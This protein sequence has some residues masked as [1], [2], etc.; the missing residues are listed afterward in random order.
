MLLYKTSLVI[1]LLHVQLFGLAQNRIKQYVQ[2]QAVEVKHIDITDS[3]FT[4]L[5]PLGVAIGNARIVALGEQMHGDGTTFE[6]K[7]RIVKYL[8]EKKGFNVLVFENDFFGLTDGFERVLKNRD[9]LNNFIFHHVIGLWSHCQRARSFF[10]NYIYQTQSTASPLILAGMDCQ[11][12]TTY[13]FQNAEAK[14][15]RILS[16]LALSVEDSNRVKIATDHLPAIYFNGQKADSAACKKGLEAVSTLLASKALPQLNNEE[17]N[18][19]ENIYAAYRNILP[20]LAGTIASSP[21]HLYRDRQMFNNLMWLMK[22]KFPNEKFIIWAH[23]AHIAKAV[24]DFADN[25]HQVIMTGELLGNKNINPYSYY[26]L[27][28]TSYNA[29]SIWT[30]NPSQPIYAEKPSK[31]SFENWINKNWNFA[32]VDWNKLN[33]NTAGN[34]PFSMKG[35]LEFTQHRNSVNYWNKLYDGVF[36]IRRVEGCKKI[37]YEDINVDSSSA[38]TEYSSDNR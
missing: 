38:A 34:E 26:S 14:L 24:K 4:D 11:L 19:V 6:A 32:F 3:Q 15:Y 12:Q 13:S 5:E 8:H 22:Y 27:G 18:F 28:F 35:S 33:T 7:G 37:N 30:N 36:F 1:C 10:Y 25:Q 21:R 31:N 17:L 29:T 2:Q 16:K 23:N 9:S 20:L